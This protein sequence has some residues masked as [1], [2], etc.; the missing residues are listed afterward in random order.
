MTPN[1]TRF[2]PGN[3]AAVTHGARSPRMLQMNR[4]A[5]S[6]EIRSLLADHLTH[7]APSDMPLL[8][9]AVDIA[10]QLRM[11]RAYL[12]RQG[13]SLITAR[14]APRPLAGTYVSLHRLLLSLWDRLGVGPAARA[15]LMGALGGGAANYRKARQQQLAAEAHRRIQ[16]EY[17]E[18]EEP[19]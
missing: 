12:D 15:S 6:V 14:G 8:D 4:D 7:L 2:K 9:Q 5:A 16:A 18:K 19:A 17:G 13:G 3:V 10:T 11:I 1:S